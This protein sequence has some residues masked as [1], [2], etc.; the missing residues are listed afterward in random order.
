MSSTITH[1]LFLSVYFIIYGLMHL[2]FFKKVKNAFKFPLIGAWL[3]SLVMMLTPILFHLA[4]DRGIFLLAK[5]FAYTGYTW[6]GF[7]FL[8]CCGSLLIDLGRLFL[9]ISP[10]VSFFVPCLIALFISVYGYFEADNIRVKKI[11][12]KTEKLPRQIESIKIV[13]ISDLHLGIMGGGK[14]L[15]KVIDLVKKINPDI[16]VSTGDL[17]D[18]DPGRLEKYSVLLRELKPRYGKYAVTGNHEYYVGTDYSIKFTEESGFKVL[19]NEYCTGEDLIVLSGVDYPEGRMSN[20]GSKDIE[21]ELLMSLPKDKF[22]IHLEHRPDIRKE[23]IGLFDLQLSGHTHR[24]QIFPLHLIVRLFYPKFY[25][26]YNLE[27][28]SY[29][30]VSAGAGTWGPQSRFLAPPEITLIE[31]SSQS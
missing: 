1:L 5:I 27:N 29:L 2:Y 31:L 8:F 3:I 23:S 15:R 19:R 12:I 10:Q 25:G 14:R 16:I 24:G 4:E 17:V 26:F 18:A 30:Y 9:H 11:E 13:Q 22:I 7:I 20:S 28:K 21:Q 6:M